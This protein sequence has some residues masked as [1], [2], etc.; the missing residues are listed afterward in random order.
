MIINSS[1]D[2]FLV[3]LFIL[4]YSKTRTLV[5]SLSLRVVMM[6][7][8]LLHSLVTRTSETYTT[9]RSTSTSQQATN[10]YL[11]DDEERLLIGCVNKSTTLIRTSLLNISRERQEVLICNCF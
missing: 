9:Q 10:N 7:A 11:R 5:R 6:E 8:N 2:H 3:F 4:V 1:I